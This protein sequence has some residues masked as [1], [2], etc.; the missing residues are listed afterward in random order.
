MLKC[1]H[2]KLVQQRV[3]FGYGAE[4]TALGGGQAVVQLQVHEVDVQYHYGFLC[5]NAFASD[6]YPASQVKPGRGQILL[7]APCEVPTTPILGFLEDGYNY[8]RF[9]DGRLL[10]G[11]GRHRFQDE[12]T[13]AEINCTA[14]VRDYL[15]QLAL[16]ISGLAQIEI[17]DHWAGIM[18][19]PNGAHGI[20]PSA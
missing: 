17:D 4:V 8:F 19:F 3:Q 5:T 14:Q 18:G 16:K 6:L 15:V 13:T 7:T 10:V 9:V 12:E 2:D 20:G 1:L 11:G